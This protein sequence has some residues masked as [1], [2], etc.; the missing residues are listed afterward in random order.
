MLFLPTQKREHPKIIYYSDHHGDWKKW[1][2]VYD[3]KG[4]KWVWIRDEKAPDERG[5]Y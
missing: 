5:L 1:K 4:D 2:L 3:K